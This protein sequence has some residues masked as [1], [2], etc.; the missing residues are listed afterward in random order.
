VLSDP[1]F[2]AE[3]APEFIGTA[4]AFHYIN[5]MVTIL[6]SPSPFPGPRALRP[7]TT[8]IAPRLFA[9]AVKRTKEAGD[10]LRFVEK[11]E[12]PDDMGWAKSCPPVASAFAGFMA[13]IDN[14]AHDAIGRDAR[15]VVEAHVGAWSGEE[16]ALSRAW[17]ETAIGE[18]SEPE[19][20][21]GRL[22][23]LT[24][25]A[26]HQIDDAVVAA[27][28]G[29]EPADRRLL[30]LLAWSSAQAARRIGTWCVP[31]A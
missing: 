8:R 17:V 6:A 23:L 22:A 7:L 3:L 26:P 16:Q 5:R 28:R 19:A 12:L 13:A 31:S 4:V 24:A 18:F 27:Y 20:A 25:L 10:S 1:P 14:E 11:A 2:D 9:R 29:H 15:A 21:A 30:A